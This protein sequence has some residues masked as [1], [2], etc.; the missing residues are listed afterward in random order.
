[1]SKDL[2]NSYLLRVYYEENLIGCK[3]YDIPFEFLFDDELERLHKSLGFAIFKL[4]YSILV[5]ITKIANAL[6][7]N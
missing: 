1:M 3:G 2:F 7:I 5:S 4:R 6:K